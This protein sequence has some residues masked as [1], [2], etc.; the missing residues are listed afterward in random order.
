MEEW[1]VGKQ[2]KTPK[3]LNNYEKYPSIQT[4]QGLANNN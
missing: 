3:E 2:N 4:P 1:K